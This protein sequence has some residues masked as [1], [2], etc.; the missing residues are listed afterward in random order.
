[1]PEKAGSVPDMDLCVIMGNM[2]EN[3]LEACRRMEGEEQFIKVRAIVDGI[4]LTIVVENSFD[5]N[6]QEEGGAYLSRKEASNIRGGGVGLSSVRA[7][8]EKHGGMMRIEINGKTW[9]SS[10]LVNMK[11]E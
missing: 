8:C 11:G 10:A 4:F 7:V 6:W 3:A 2:L 1:M 9:K 5:G